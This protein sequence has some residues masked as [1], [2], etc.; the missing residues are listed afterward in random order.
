MCPI[1]L[2]SFI[3]LDVFK[4]HPCY[5]MRQVLHFFLFIF[6]LLNRIP[7][8]NRPHF[9]CSPVVEIRFLF[10]LLWIMLWWAF[11]CRFLC[12]HP[13]P[14]LLGI[15]WQA[16]LLGHVVTLCYAVWGIAR[17]LSKVVTPF[18]TPSKQCMSTPIF[19]QFLKH[20][21]LSILLVIAI[22]MGLKRYFV[23]GLISYFLDD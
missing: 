23:V 11:V 16:Q 3:K 22:S 15:Y 19:P 8:I 12:G 13:F 4:G 2:S 10:L 6:L 9:V 20:S 1:W 7:F 18:Y 5:N 14:F 17:L 21:L